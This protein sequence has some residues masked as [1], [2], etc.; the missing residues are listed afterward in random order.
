M[1]DGS[2]QR[3]QHMVHL[4]HKHVGRISTQTTIVVLAVIALILH[5]IQ[6]I[7]L[8]FVISGLL[9]YICT[10]AVEWLTGRTHMPR[11]FFA[12]ALFIVLVGAA[13]GM[14]LLCVQAL[15]P[16]LSDVLANFQSEVAGLLRG[17]IG[18]GRINLFGR[19]MDASQLA[20]TVSANIVDWIKQS[21][22]IAVLGGFAIASVFGVFLTLVLLFY[23]LL[24][25][26]GIMRG[27]LW[28][29]PPNQRP[30]IR[31]IWLR[32]DPV[33]KR[34][35]VGIIVVVSYAIAAAYV[36]L[37]LV[38]GIPDAIFLAFLTGLLEMIPIVGP[39]AAAIIAG[40]IAVR[41]ATGIGP[42]I[43]YA[44]YATVLRLSIDQLFGPLALGTAAR[45]HPTLIIFCFLSGGLL[46][47][48]T[49]VIL[50]V[51]VALIIKV[52]L[53]TLYDDERTLGEVTVDDGKQ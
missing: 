2:R 30:L 49:G 41:H 22:G 6:W 8:P 12:A 35:F 1:S 15:V 3:P 48:I 45:V 9:A 33:L 29:V 19:P 16:E 21:G 26:P 51:P 7:L 10:P 50:A 27:L 24:G 47:G 38:L 17:V 42:I 43:G 46:F 40:L 53:A 11:A 31:H 4:D 34:Y 52:T 5:A 37:G 44:I 39:G 32:L 28:L 20:G 36:G 14:G 23:F 25:G 13:A 18:P